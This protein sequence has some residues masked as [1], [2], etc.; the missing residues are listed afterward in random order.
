MPQARKGK[1]KALVQNLCDVC[2][3]ILRMRNR[4]T[5]F[6]HLLHLGSPSKIAQ[7]EDCAL[8]RITLRLLEQSGV[9]KNEINSTV[10]L[11]PRFCDGYVGISI[12]GSPPE[13]SLGWIKVVDTAVQLDGVNTQPHSSNEFLHL[14][15][16]D[17]QKI[18]LWL[19]ECDE[20]HGDACRDQQSKSTDREIQDL[21]LIDVDRESLYVAE[22]DTDFVALSYVWGS[23]RGRNI[24]RQTTQTLPELTSNGSLRHFQNQIP[25]VVRDAMTL[26]RLIGQKYLWCDLLCIREDEKS[27]KHRQI[28]QMDAIYEKAILTIIA[29]SGSHSFESLPGLIPGSRDPICLSEDLGDGALLVSRAPRLAEVERHTLYESRGWTFQERLISRRCL[30]LTGRQ[31][32]FQCP[33]GSFRED[34]DVGYFQ[35][36]QTRDSQMLYSQPTSLTRL[37]SEAE[38]F[39][40]YATLISQ[41]TGRQLTYSSDRL[42]AFE[43]IAQILGRKFGAELWGGLPQT[44]LKSALMWRPA[45]SY[46]ELRDSDS[47]PPPSWSWGAWIGKI[48]I[49]PCTENLTGLQYPTTGFGFAGPIESAKTLFNNPDSL[50]PEFKIEKT[51]YQSAQLR[52]DNEQQ[53]PWFYRQLPAGD[54]YFFRYRF[55]FSDYIPSSGAPSCLLR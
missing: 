23:I 5:A 30:F 46:L 32:Y 22:P 19:Q 8:C 41:Y 44:H 26:C 2:H 49:D 15:E 6:D 38:P 3:P 53:T 36:L 31:M 48:R 29:L 37:I 52:N 17:P 55:Y 12:D 9:G 28:R 47:E 1:G 51:L 33:S 34:D 40:T 45:T 16:I 21:F 20:H 39:E 43:G 35:G 54:R 42:K 27:T 50:M 13:E 14:S 24:L 25:N 4:D 11:N 10:T 7:R 18:S